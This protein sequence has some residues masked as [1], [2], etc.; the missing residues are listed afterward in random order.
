VL[1]I[2]RH[3]FWEM[4]KTSLAAVALFCFV[5]IAGNAIKEI[6]GFLLDGR[7]GL[8][9]FLQ[10][11]ALLVPY[12]A[13]YALPMGILMAI[14]LILG[15]MC[16]KG[17]YVAYRACGVSLWVLAKP[18]L[19]LASLCVIFMAGINLYYAPT[20]RASYFT[21]FGS[22]M[23]SDP[24]R[25]VV[26]GTFVKEFPGYILYARDRKEH[27]LKDFWIWELNA[28][29]Q[30][31]KLI[32]AQ[33]G[34]IVYDASSDA[35]ELTLQ[36]G[37][38]ELRDEKSPDDLKTVRPTLAF[39]SAKLKLPLNRLVSG[40]QRGGLTTMTLDKL[41]QRQ[42]EL[43]LKLQSAPED[44]SLGGDLAQVRFQLSQDFA[45]AFAVLALAFVGIPL[46][47][48]ASRSETYA[49]M[50][51]ALGLGLAYYFLVVVTSWFSRYP[52]LHPEMLV[53][54][55]NLFFCGIGAAL[56][57]HAAKN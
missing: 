34:R 43:V 13:S 35:L 48:K 28:H 55:P 18:I 23:R 38:S 7:L 51:I 10:L 54:A 3:I 16:S 1:L 19:F 52:A 15:R 57:R 4:V 49:N 46:G 50:A 11:L 44:T 12:V 33:T 40:E 9:M 14:L 27:T 2:H 37:F 22:M 39:D 32:R 17:E 53:W 21:A 26:P 31:V 20:A 30:P 42:Q 25:F 36:N 29:N 24:L 41:L 45:F 56:F 6:L 5:M 8:G 47:L